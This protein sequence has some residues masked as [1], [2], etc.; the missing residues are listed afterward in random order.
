MWGVWRFPV[1]T[2]VWSHPESPTAT[3]VRFRFRFRFSLMDI[4]DFIAWGARK[5]DKTN[6]Q[7]LELVLE[8]GVEAELGSLVGMCGQVGRGVEVL[9]LDAYKRGVLGCWGVS[10][11][12]AGVSL[13]VMSVLGGTW[14]SFLGRVGVSS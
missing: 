8:R 4:Q 12:C 1:S 6:V 9:V 7:K 3:T 13:V 10:W 2:N 5:T 14:W 11:A